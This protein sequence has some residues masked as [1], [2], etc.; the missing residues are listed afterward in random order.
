MSRRMRMRFEERHRE[1]ERIARDLHDT[2]LQSFHGLLLRFQAVANLL[3]RED[4][5]RASLEQV[6]DRGEQALV[7]GRERVQSL[8]QAE[9]GNADRLALLDRIQQWRDEIQAT[10]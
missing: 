5:I 1:R 4:P 3:G 6:M 10:L 7:E 9:A 8:R 2:L